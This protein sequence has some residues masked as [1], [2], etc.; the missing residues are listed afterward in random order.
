MGSVVLAQDSQRFDIRVWERNGEHAVSVRA[1]GERWNTERIDLDRE[2]A[3]DWRCADTTL[4][5]P[6]PGVGDG[7]TYADGYAA[8]AAQV[9]A[10]RNAGYQQGLAQS[11]NR[12]WDGY[13]AGEAAG[14]ANAPQT[15]CPA[16]RRQYDAALC[17]VCQ[18]TE[19]ERLRNGG[20]TS[21]G[22]GRCYSVCGF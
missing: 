11:D 1:E 13:R 14:R 8:G 10:A 4:S 9:E 2:C 6:L 21:P 3:N 7:R 5:V 12:Y 18:E 17:Q 19:R 16:P 20:S 15:T 22:F